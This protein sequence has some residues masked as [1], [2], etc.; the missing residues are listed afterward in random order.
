VILKVPELKKKTKTK[1]TGYIYHKKWGYGSYLGN[2]FDVT[3]A[4]P[5]VL[6]SIRTVMEVTI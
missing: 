5:L 1:H 3:L 2:M 4:V 6:Q